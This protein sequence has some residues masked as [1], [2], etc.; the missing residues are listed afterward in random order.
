MVQVGE[1]CGRKEARDMCELAIACTWSGST[2]FRS[3]SVSKQV[4]WAQARP[5]VRVLQIVISRDLRV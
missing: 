1:E 4:R 3:S 5:C 2:P